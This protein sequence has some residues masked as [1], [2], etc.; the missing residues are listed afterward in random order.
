MGVTYLFKSERLGFRNW[1]PSDIEKMVRIN[2]DKEVMQFFPA[3]PSIQETT[4]FIERMQTQFAKKNYCYFAVDELASGTFI[5]FIGLSDQ[6]YESDFT[7][8]TDIGWRLR[9]S[10]W[11]RGYATEGAKACLEYA[12]Q[13]LNIPEIFAVASKVNLNSIN[14]M[15]KI[16]MSYVKN[17]EHPGLKHNARLKTCVL[18][19]YKKRSN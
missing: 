16:G 9:R 10:S 1:I 11:S 3:L 6:T 18:Y 17:F 13:E 12:K 8:H 4:A 5:G 2:A 15:E 7:P 19:R 14:V